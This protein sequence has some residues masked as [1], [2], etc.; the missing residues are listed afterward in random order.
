MYNAKQIEVLHSNPNL[1]DQPNNCASHEYTKWTPTE[2]LSNE[3]LQIFD[4]FEFWVANKVN[5]MQV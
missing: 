3:H 1:H 2:Q 5:L 4:R